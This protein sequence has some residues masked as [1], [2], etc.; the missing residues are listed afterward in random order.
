MGFLRMLRAGVGTG[1]TVLLSLLSE[2]PNC[3]QLGEGAPC[4]AGRF[5]GITLGLPIRT[6]Q[7]YQC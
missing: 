7:L 2:G 5:E 4:Y 1:E 3:F 6:T